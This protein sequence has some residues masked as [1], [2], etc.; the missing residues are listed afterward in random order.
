MHPTKS[1]VF[2]A[3]TGGLKKPRLKLSCGEPEKS[4]LNVQKRDDLDLRDSTADIGIQG[5]SI[6]I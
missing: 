4:Q 3:I 5:A 2:Q 1:A 6:S